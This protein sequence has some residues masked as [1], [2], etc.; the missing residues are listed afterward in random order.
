MPQSRIRGYSMAGW[1]YAFKALSSAVLMA[2]ACSPTVKDRVL[3]FTPNAINEAK[4]LLGGYAAGQPVGSES[5][6]FDDFVQRVA[7]VDEAKAAELRAFFDDA[8]AKGVANRA[9]A[10]ELLDRW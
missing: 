2:A 4:A 7:D 6:G 10:K 5:E 9:K 1:S 8:V 3:P